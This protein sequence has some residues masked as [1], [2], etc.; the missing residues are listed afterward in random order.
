[1]VRVEKAS[2]RSKRN[3]D[4]RP[5]QRQVIREEVD[6]LFSNL[7]EKHVHVHKESVTPPMF[8]QQSRR[9]N[10]T[11]NEALSRRHQQQSTT[12]REKPLPSRSVGCHPE[13]VHN[14]GLVILMEL[15]LLPYWSQLYMMSK[16]G[17][18]KGAIIVKCNAS[19]GGHNLTNLILLLE[20]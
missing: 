12:S 15:H 18:S 10:G 1:L 2:T 20:H 17:L 11:S 9:K 5:T 7:Q 14:L 16:R 6:E 19:L 13:N 3:K 8:G 4:D